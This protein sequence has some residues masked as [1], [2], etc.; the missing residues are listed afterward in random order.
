MVRRSEIF[1][2]QLPR[3][4]Y[5]EVDPSKM[6]IRAIKTFYSIDEYPKAFTLTLYSNVLL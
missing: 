3:S 5:L 2:N 1:C 4:V 6:D